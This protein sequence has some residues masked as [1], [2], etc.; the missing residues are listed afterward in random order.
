MNKR[1]NDLTQIADGVPRPLL[2]RYL[3]DTF[4]ESYRHF[5][6]K[7]EKFSTSWNIDNSAMLFLF[8]TIENWPAHLDYVLCQVNPQSEQTIKV[9]DLQEVIEGQHWS[10]LS[11]LEYL[12]SNQVRRIQ[13]YQN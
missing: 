3:A 8:Q 9:E 7:R 6:E 5:T 4:P 2:E 1:L 10:I 12:A 11:V 13:I